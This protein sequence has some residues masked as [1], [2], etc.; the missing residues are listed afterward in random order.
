MGVDEDPLRRLLGTLLAATAA[1]LDTPREIGEYPIGHV[2]M[3][4]VCVSG[5]PLEKQLNVDLLLSCLRHTHII[6]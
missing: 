2:R 3:A 5:V 4:A 1:Y 6:G